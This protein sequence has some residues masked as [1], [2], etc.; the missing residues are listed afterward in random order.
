MAADAAIGLDDVQELA[1]RFVG[2]VDAV[3]VRP[4]AGEQS[5]IRDLDQAPSI[6]TVLCNKDRAPC[7]GRVAD[8]FIG[9]S[10]GQQNPTV[11]CVMFGDPGFSSVDGGGN[12]F[13]CPT[14][15]KSPVIL[16]NIQWTR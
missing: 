7:T 8:L 6:P 14:H 9:K 4:G 15:P 13:I 2:D 5:L 16:N 1:L 12:Q 11:S 10:Y 3:A